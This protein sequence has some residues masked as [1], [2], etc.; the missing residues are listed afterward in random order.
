MTMTC[1][2]LADLILDFVGAELPPEQRAAFEYHLC[3]CGSCKVA[4]E[5]YQATVTV[6]RALGRCG[7]D[8][9]PT[10][11]EARLRAVLSIHPVG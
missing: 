2:E 1:E 3:G 8:P 6:T 7:C 10:A 9:L 11:V 5:M 4:V